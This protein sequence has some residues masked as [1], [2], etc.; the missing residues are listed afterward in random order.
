MDNS[1][2]NKIPKI[3]ICAFACDPKA[4]S[5]LGA[6]E[7]A[8]GWNII[9]QAIRFFDVWVLCSSKNKTNVEIFLIN[10]NIKNLHFYYV[11]LPGWISRLFWAIWSRGGSQIYYYIWQIKIY[12]VAKSLNKKINFDIFHHATYANDWMASYIGA[13][14]PV[15]YVRGPGGGAQKTPE[16]F[17]R[18][19]FLK[20]RISDMVR[21]IGQWLF[22]HD[23][24]FVIGQ[25]KAKAIL[26][27]NKE[28]FDA[29]PKKWQEKT[30]FFPVNGV[31]RQ[32][33]IFFDSQAMPKPEDNFNILSLQENN[34]LE[35]YTTQKITTNFLN[36]ELF[37][38]QE[39]N[40]NNINLFNTTKI[41]FDSFNDYVLNKRIKKG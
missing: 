19:Y 8:L 7:D 34:S 23:P 22:R 2:N 17:F 39:E 21:S 15:S 20:G 40:Y 13:L 4:N 38:N 29:L 10:S 12:F 31:S 18:N 3:L 33:F 28:S 37:F 26:V 9:T 6:G 27:C 30:Y 36:S 35:K 16:K 11:D 1:K 24:F 41:N 14:L 25:K 32:D 5:G